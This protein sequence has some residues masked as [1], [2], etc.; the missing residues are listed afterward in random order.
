VPEA[1]DLRVHEDQH[2]RFHQLRTRSL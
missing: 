2:L 1:V